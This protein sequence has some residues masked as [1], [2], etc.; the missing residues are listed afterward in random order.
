MGEHDD[1]PQQGQLFD[2][3]PLVYCD[4]LIEAGLWGR[5]LVDVDTG[6]RT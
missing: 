1:T 5:P 2:V 4:V 3:P 6:G